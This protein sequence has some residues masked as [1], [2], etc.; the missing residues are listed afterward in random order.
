[1][2][3]EKLKKL[4]LKLC[5][6]KQNYMSAFRKNIDMYIAEKDITLREIAEKADISFDTLKTFVYGDS[7]DCKLSTAVKLS[8]AFHVSID[9]L[10]GAETVL[11]EARECMALYRNLPDNEKYLVRWYVSYINTLNKK[12]EKGHR[13][14]SVMQ[15]ECNHNGNLKITTTYSHLDITDIDEEYRYKVFFGI[16]IPCDHYMPLYSPYDTLLIANDR[17]PLSSENCLIRMNGNLY[18][19]KRKV[20]NG[21]VKYFSA[22]NGKNELNENDIDELV[23]YI[24]YVV[25]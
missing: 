3:N 8:R 17:N 22:R 14:I 11:P 13:Y 23:G 15:L 6:D 12:N 10:V 4:S 21:H 24:A 18:I 25:K 9:E 2:E 1:M 19:A 16:K 7:K 20:E 5:S